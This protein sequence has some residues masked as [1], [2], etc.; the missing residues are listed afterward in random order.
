MTLRKSKYAKNIN[1]RC[2]AAQTDE[3][4]LRDQINDCLT[5]L[6]RKKE[7]PSAA[8]LARVVV[9]TREVSE[10]LRSLRPLG[11]CCDGKTPFALATLKFTAGKL[12]AYQPM[13]ATPSQPPYLHGVVIEKI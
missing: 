7:T 10:T 11:S 6:S 2:S 9:E 4:I 1:V 13:P 3:R 5:I 12:G 8:V